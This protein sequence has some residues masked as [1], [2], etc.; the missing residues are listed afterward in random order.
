[1]PGIRLEKFGEPG[2]VD[3]LAGECPAEVL[4]DV[5]VPEGHR[6]RVAEGALGHLGARPDPDSRQRPQPPVGVGE[7]ELA[8]LLESSAPARGT[9]RGSR[10]GGVNAGL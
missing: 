7:R 8:A 4:G 2:V 1:V 6:V 9:D 3:L 5:V 10:A